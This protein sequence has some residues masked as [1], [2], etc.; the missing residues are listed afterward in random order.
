MIQGSVSRTAIGAAYLWAAHLLL[1]AP[2]RIRDDPVILS[3]LGPAARQRIK[4][5]ADHYQSPAWRALRAHVALRSRFAEDRLAAAVLRGIKQYVILGAGL[6]TF[7]L[8]QPP[9]AKGL[10]ILEVDHPGTQHRKRSLLAAAGLAMPANASFAAIDFETETL[11][12]VLLR[13]Q[14]TMDS[15]AFFSWLGVTMYLGEEAKMPCSGPLQD[16]LPAARSC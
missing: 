7:T 15:P 10:K 2:P 5:H 12:A 9:W 1:D 8:R 6:D 4:D 11:Q 16:F 3:L 14:V 13:H